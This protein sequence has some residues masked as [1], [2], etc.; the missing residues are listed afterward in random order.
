MWA[1]S[2]CRYFA[3]LRSLKNAVSFS[4]VPKIILWGAGCVGAQYIF[5]KYLKLL[6]YSHFY[7][8]F[9]THD[10]WKLFFLSKIC[11]QKV[12]DISRLSKKPKS[13]SVQFQNLIFNERRTLFSPLKYINFILLV[14]LNFFFF[15]NASFEIIFDTIIAV[16]TNFEKL[17]E[18]GDWFWRK[19]WNWW[20]QQ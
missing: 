15:K 4:K 17:R 8:A 5:R 18:I 19:L 9:N 10:I 14:N 2:V 7:F 11:Q 6:H 3:R 20:K 16:F 13:R 1:N 12:S